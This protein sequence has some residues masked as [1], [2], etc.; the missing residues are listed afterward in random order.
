MRVHYKGMALSIA[1]LAAS[2]APGL[3]QTVQ[4]GVML[5]L[6]GDA[7]QHKIQYDCGALG[8]LDVTYI[9]AAPNF[10]ALL[11][12]D[13]QTLIFASALS[14][15]GARYVSGIY[16]WWTKGA[17]ATLTD[18]TAVTDAPALATC[19]EITTTP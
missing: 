1:L 14:A 4:S 16:E 10:L 5:K 9:N 6:D 3:A 15:S 11:P 18:L 17:E 13:D 2:I 8:Q 19:I 12:Y 7:E